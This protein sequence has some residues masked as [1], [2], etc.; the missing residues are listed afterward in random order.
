M[1]RCNDQ[2]Q[3]DA[4]ADFDEQ[5]EKAAENARKADL[6]YQAQAQ[7]LEDMTPV[8]RE[9][10]LCLCEVEDAEV[11]CWQHAE[12]ALLVLWAA[13]GG[14]INIVKHNPRYWFYLFATNS[15]DQ[16]RFIEPL[17]LPASVHYKRDNWGYRLYRNGGRNGRPQA[18]GHDLP[19][20][21]KR[22]RAN[23]ARADNP[24]LGMVEKSVELCFKELNNNYKYAIDQVWEKVRVGKS[25]SRTLPA[26]DFTWRWEITA[27]KG[28][29]AKD[30]EIVFAVVL[31]AT[32]RGGS[33]RSEQLPEVP[34]R[35]EHSW[36]YFT[37]KRER[38]KRRATAKATHKGYRRR[39]R[40]R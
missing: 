33:W 19:S 30:R 15:E 39:G 2:A 40:L 8:L 24:N 38:R 21:L 23:I 12:D 9:N 16:K 22:Y 34:R 31:V 36:R 25:G 5:R 32:R 7:F 3:R 29:V 28:S 20:A 37:A 35:A 1:A 26:K 11:P 17:G 18:T 10:S 27:P 4:Q 13:L 6:R 14:E